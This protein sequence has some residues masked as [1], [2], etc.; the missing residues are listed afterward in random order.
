MSVLLETSLGDIVVDLYHEEC[1]LAAR[2]FVKLCKSKFYNNCLF[3]KVEKGHLAFCGDPHRDGGESIWHRLGSNGGKKDS[4]SP[5]KRFFADEVQPSLTHAKR[6]TLGMATEKPDS[7]G[8][9]FYITLADGKHALDGAH[10]IFGRIA[11]EEGLEVLDKLN[12]ML[13][14][15]AGR[16]YVHV[17]IRHTVLLDDPFD[18]IGDE[19]GYESPD[20]FRDG[21]DAL[22]KAKKMAGIGDLKTANAAN[23]LAAQAQESADALAEQLERIKAADARS[24]AITLELLQDLPDAD[25]KPPDNVLFI[26]KLNPVTQDSDLQLLFERFGLIRSCEIIRDFKTGDSLQYAFIEY[27]AERDAEEA[28]FKMQG[29][30]VDGRRIHVDFSQSISKSFSMFKSGRIGADELAALGV[31]KGAGSMTG[32]GEQKDYSGGSK[33]GKKGD[34]KKGGGKYKGGGFKGKDSSSSSKGGLFNREQTHRPREY[35]DR[36]PAHHERSTSTSHHER[37]RPNQHGHGSDGHRGRGTG[38]HDRRRNRRS[39]SR[40]RKRQNSRSRSGHR[41]HFN[42]EDKRYHDDDR[43]AKRHR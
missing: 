33:D 23:P 41:S 40:R 30:L 4:D 7:N 26:A 13:C 11:E 8:S 42:K 12:E 27:E 19:E 31:E 20:E 35:S 5:P 3:D 1:P 15:P 28:F 21:E 29:V 25:I 24:Q 32:K 9:K 22:D 39:E 38:D 14:D 37:E 16:P 6:G 10:T 2:N 34:G 17:R 43:H 36:P 18:D